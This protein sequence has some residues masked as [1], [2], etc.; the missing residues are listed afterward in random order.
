MPGAQTN[1]A[2]GLHCSPD[3]KCDLQCTQAGNECG[4]GYT[5]TVDGYCVGKGSGD[6]PPDMP[7]P[8]VHLTGARTIPTVELLL[9]QSGSMT[10][11]YGNT[12]RWQALRNAL[13]DPTNGVV[14]RLAGSV[15]FGATLYS[16]NSQDVNGTQVGIPPCPK[17]TTR[18]RALNN[19]TAIRQLLQGANPDE[20]TPTGESI[21]AVVADFAAKPPMQGSP[22]IILLA[23]DGLPDTCADADPPNQARQDATNAVSVAAAQRA[24]AAG[25]KLFFL[26]I[27]NEAAG[28]HPQ[29]MANAGAGKD[30]LTGNAPFYV[31]TDPAQLTAAFNTIIGGVVS[32]DIRLTGGMVDPADAATGTVVVNGQTLTFGTDWTMDNDRVT[33][34]IIGAAC[35]RLKTSMNPTVDASFACGAVIF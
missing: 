14:S 27:G 5:C 18:P 1:C 35:D 33:V 13:I 15:V 32:C 6:V 12:N 31:A 24:Y 3:G 21:D 25:I 10:A 20:D 22:P 30:P 17:L 34:H 23:T 11:A 29:Q 7:C 9:D 8:E 28:N 16:S 19:A 26:F 2:A 4:D